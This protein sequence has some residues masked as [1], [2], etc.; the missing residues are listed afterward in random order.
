M[1][2][3][4]LYSVIFNFV[5]FIIDLIPSFV[6]TFDDYTGGTIT[7]VAN[8]LVIFPVDLW[9]ILIVNIVFFLTSAL[10]WVVVE[11]IYKKIPGVD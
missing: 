2:I 10:A 7:L 9:I 4:G 5:G 8:A 6:G 11:W 1:I 3:E